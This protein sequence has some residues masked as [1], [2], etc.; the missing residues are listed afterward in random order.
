MLEYNAVSTT[1][2]QARQH[3]RL[4]LSNDASEED[5][6]KIT[7]NGTLITSLSVKDLRQLGLTE[8]TQPCSI[9]FRKKKVRYRN[10][11]KKKKI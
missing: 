1:L 11:K 5:S 6:H 8:D 3:N 9:G 4:Y 7:L 10:R 2:Q